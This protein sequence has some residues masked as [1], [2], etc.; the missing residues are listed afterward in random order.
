MRDQRFGNA[1]SLE[2]TSSFSESQSF[3]LREYVGQQDVMMAAERRERFCK[4]NEIAGDD[5]RALVKK[6]IKGMLAVGPRLTP[7]NRTCVVVHTLSL[8]CHRLPVAFHR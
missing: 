3:S 7:K 1:V 8:P 5:S 2:F 4:R 6:L